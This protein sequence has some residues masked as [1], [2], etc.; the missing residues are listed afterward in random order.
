MGLSRLEKD[1]IND[2]LNS[3]L[4]FY[5]GFGGIPYSIC[6]SFEEVAK[7]V[8]NTQALNYVEGWDE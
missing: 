7:I 2:L 4:K 1:A 6:P 3:I 8:N 5:K